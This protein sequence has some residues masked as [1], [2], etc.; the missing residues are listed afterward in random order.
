MELSKNVKT[1]LSEAISVWA[2]EVLPGRPAILA[3]CVYFALEKSLLEEQEKIEKNF[4]I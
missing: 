3:N 4:P 2:D 1:K